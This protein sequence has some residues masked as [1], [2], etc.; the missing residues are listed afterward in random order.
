MAE[1]KDQNIKVYRGES[2]FNLGG[3]KLGRPEDVG[4]WYTPNIKKSRRYPFG[5]SGI[6][7]AVTRSMDVSPEEMIKASYKAF[8]SHAK[9]V[10]DMNLEKGVDKD[11]AYN[12]FFETMN[13]I[14]GF[15]S[16]QLDKL[17]KG[18][19]SQDDIDRLTSTTMQEG[20]FDNKG[21]ID[22]KETFKRGNVLAAGGTA[23]GRALPYI[24][25]GLGIA[26]LP[27]DFIGGANQTAQD[28]QE[29]VAQAYGIDP[30]VFYQ[31]DPEQFGEIKQNYDMMVAK[32]R[33]Q[34][35]ADAQTIS[36]MVP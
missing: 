13:Q 25:K 23:V 20:V 11:V 8:E 34:Q 21:K 27:I 9:T 32:M 12:R 19:L 2:L 26:A 15:H 36:P 28:P 31:M 24:A 10:L 3:T 14:D 18:L 16:E 1:A 29:E 35:M 33:D 5:E 7:G 6:L 17:N 22:I 30:S 4:R